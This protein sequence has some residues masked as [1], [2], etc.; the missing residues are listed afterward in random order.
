ML[1]RDIAA[2]GTMHE[3]YDS[4]TGL[5]L[6]PTAEESPGGKFTGFVGWNLLAEDM[7]QCEVAKQHCMMLAS[8][9]SAK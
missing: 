6:A 8:P 7:L 3:D 4:D 2:V 9:H 1:A 5:G